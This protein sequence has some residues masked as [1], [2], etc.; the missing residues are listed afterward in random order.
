MDSDDNDSDTFYD[1]VQSTLNSSFTEEDY[2]TL[3]FAFKE[4]RDKDNNNNPIISSN[5]N[6][7]NINFIYSS[8]SNSMFTDQKRNPLLESLSTRYEN[9]KEAFR[10]DFEKTQ[11]LI[12]KYKPKEEE[13]E[14][15]FE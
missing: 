2:N 1:L 4:F 12:L 7:S 5:S 14:I 11:E 3:V 10:R 13:A 9:N 6:S 15:E 8:T